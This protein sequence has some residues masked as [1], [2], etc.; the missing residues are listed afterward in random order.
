M[1]ADALLLGLL[2]LAWGAQAVLPWRLADLGAERRR[3]GALAL[4]PLLAIG[5]LAALL[6]LRHHLPAAVSQKLF[7]LAGS[8]PGRALA[9]LLPAMAAADLLL[10][11][12]WRRLETAGWRIAGGFGL[13]FL[14]AVTWAAELVRTGEGPASSPTVLLLLVILRGLVALGAAEALA[15]GRPLLAVAAGPGLLLY[16]LLLPAQLAQALGARGHWLTLASAALLLL[17]ARWLPSSLRRVVLLGAT[18]LAGLYCSQ[19]VTLSER[20]G[21]LVPLQ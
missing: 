13:L 6:Y 16:G 2:L 21:A 14:L 12:G 11:L 8:R 7:P 1:I 19:A 17:A 9:V 10:A 20:L 15:P 3:A 18:L 5:L 4:L